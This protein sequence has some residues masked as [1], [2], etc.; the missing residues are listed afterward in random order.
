VLIIS[1]Y[2]TW[3]LVY[4]VIVIAITICGNRDACKSVCNECFISIFK[5]LTC[6]II[7]DWMHMLLL[8]DRGNSW[9]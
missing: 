1:V 6:E 4:V 3:Q 9:L 2:R 7:V 5:L 8:G